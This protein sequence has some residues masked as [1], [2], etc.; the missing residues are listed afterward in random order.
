MPFKHKIV[1]AILRRAATLC[2]NGLNK[3]KVQKI[4]GR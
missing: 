1:S 3:N 4:V 2:E